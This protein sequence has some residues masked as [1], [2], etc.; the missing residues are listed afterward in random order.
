ML[1]GTFDA[2]LQPL[3]SLSV[4]ELTDTVEIIDVCAESLEPS[5]QVSAHALEVSDT[6]LQEI[7]WVRLTAIHHI[8]VRSLRS[9]RHDVNDTFPF[10]IRLMVGTN[11]DVTLLDERLRS[12]TLYLSGEVLEG[13]PVET[14]T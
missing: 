6:R 12:A 1:P 8:H 11:D 4:E 7:L 13:D 2:S 10:R 14:V 9:H 5:E 3:S